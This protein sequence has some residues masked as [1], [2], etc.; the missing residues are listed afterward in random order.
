MSNLTILS[1][2]TTEIQ[3]LVKD[4][5]LFFHANDLATILGFA[6][7]RDAIKNH[8]EAE[9]V[10]KADTLTKGGKQSVNF[11][12]ESGMY[13]LILGS[14]KDEAKRFKKWVTSEVLP[15]IRK[16]GTYEVATNSPAINIVNPPIPHGGELYK[17]FIA[18]VNMQ[19]GD[20]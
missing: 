17:T 20:E 6:N 10:A 11:V 8:V 9:D 1:F 5:E 12:N 19:R 16:T 18:T 14:T 2:E 13:A 15:T 7:P 4:G 3:T